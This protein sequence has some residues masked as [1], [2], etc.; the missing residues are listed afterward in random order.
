M[1]AD[2]PRET[3]VTSVST[4]SERPRSVLRYPWLYVAVVFALA[5]SP[6]IFWWSLVIGVSLLVVSLLVRARRARFSLQAT[7]VGLVLGAAPYPIL[8][9]LQNAF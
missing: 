2:G 5:T 6:F 1:S 3:A 9:L 7:G 8:G 4:A